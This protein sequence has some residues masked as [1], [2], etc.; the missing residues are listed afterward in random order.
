MIFFK[1]KEEG[2]NSADAQNLR[3][4]GVGAV[5]RMSVRLLAMCFQ[6][7]T[8]LA[9]LSQDCVGKTTPMTADDSTTGLRA[10]SGQ[11]MLRYCGRQHLQLHFG[12]ADRRRYVVL[13]RISKVGGSPG[14]SEMSTMQRCHRFC[15]LR[16]LGPS[17]VQLKGK[18]PAY[19]AG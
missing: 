7:S 3:T 17:C 10:F 16:L 1:E 14:F 15:V 4:G 5:L 9:P 6:I 18:S 11:E 13:P 8:P 2:D 12:K 19:F